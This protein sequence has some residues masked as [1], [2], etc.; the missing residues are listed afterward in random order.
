MKNAYFDSPLDYNTLM[1]HVEALCEH[2]DSIE[3]SYLGN[4]LFSRRIPMLSVG[5]RGA[6]EIFY[7]AGHHATE[8]L[9]TGVQLSFIAELCEKLE[10]GGRAFGISLE[11]LT[12]TR[13]IVIVPQLN[14][15]GT[16][17]H[18]NGVP[19]DCP[20]KDRLE[21]AAGGDFSRWQANGRGIDLNHNYN[22]R[23]Y[24][25]KSMERE[26]GI[27]SAAP[28]R[29]SGEYPESEP[30]TAALANYLRYS[31]PRLILSLHSQGEVI[32]GADS[33]VR[34]AREIAGRLG[35]A[36]GYSLETPT[37]AAACGGLCDWY[38]DECS[39]PA[40]TLECGKGENPL[41]IESGAGI[42][43]RLRRALFTAA[44]MV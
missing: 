34:G 13:R 26:M 18:I 38:A 14:V 23:F 28:T 16:D 29:Y 41:P 20:I 25:Y 32:Y 21:R 24:E 37:G 36:C 10:C 11:Y 30:E 42:Y 39:A 40:L 33:G 27:F 17:I 31:R 43:A 44:S 22:A 4:S 12:R 35:D 7:V 2:Y 1:R 6:P 19:V 9:C 8:W 3:L 5:R 15:D